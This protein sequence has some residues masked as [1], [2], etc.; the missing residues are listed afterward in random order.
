MDL[1]KLI[2]ELEERVNDA[3]NI[4]NYEAVFALQNFLD[5]I[6]ENS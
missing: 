1:T 2:T 6:I 5:W 4:E 3:N